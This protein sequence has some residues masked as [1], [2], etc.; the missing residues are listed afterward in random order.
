MSDLSP[1]T[2]A[3]DLLARFRRKI[4]ANAAA[5]L[6]FVQAHGDDPAALD[7]ELANLSKA[8]QQALT[9]P[10]ARDEGLAL[11]GET[12]SHIDRRGLWQE[13]HALLTDGLRVSR[14]IG[15]PQHEARLLDQLGEAA[16]LLGDNRLAQE[17]FEAAIGRY[18]SLAEPAGAGRALAHLSQVQLARNDW[19]AAGQSCQQ[20]VAMLTGL[21]RPN[22]LALAHN[23]W[24]IVCQ[25][26]GRLEEALT[27]FEQAEAGFRA[28]GALRG[29][30]KVILNRGDTYRRQGQR[31]AAEATFR[32]AL[33][34]YEESGDRLGMAILQM[35]LSI[36]LYE[37]DQPAEALGLSL[38]AETALRR[39]RNRSIL[40]R[41]CN[42]H[43]IF[44]TA[45]GRL[46]EAEEAFEESARLHHE[47]GDRLYAASALINAAEVLID[48]QRAAEASP[49]LA[50]ARDWLDTLAQAPRWLRNDYQ[51][52][53]ARLE[54]LAGAQPA[55]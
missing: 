10:L 12:W 51:T 50:Q 23:N 14:E 22:E 43:G 30:A 28:A 47:N 52:Q 39:L 18:R 40:A 20:A 21:D 54:A 31:D 7:R 26:Q 32:R 6:D 34:L 48:Q 27:H 46:S 5:W 33:P 36:V 17:H 49:R 37:R 38:E 13:W 45:L 53:S 2:A 16:R 29:Q 15:R 4:A 24:G 55:P 25:E 35:N 1:L 42:N 44:L 9:E 11:V 41:V 19:D 8:A 3:D